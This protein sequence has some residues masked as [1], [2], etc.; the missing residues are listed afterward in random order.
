MRRS[1]TCIALWL[2]VFVCVTFNLADAAD[3]KD[4]AIQSLEMLGPVSDV[5]Y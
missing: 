4:D 1:Y 5:Q 3:K 2:G